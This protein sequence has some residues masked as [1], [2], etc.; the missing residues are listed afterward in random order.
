MPVTTD[1]GSPRTREIPALAS[2]VPP[3]AEQLP[4]KF[5]RRGR[6]R[7]FIRRWI[8]AG[9]LMTAALLAVL[10][11]S[12]SIAINDLLEQ[13]TS[14]ERERDLVRG[15]NERLRGELLRLMSVERVSALASERLGLVQPA[16]PPIALPAQGDVRSHAVGK[17]GGNHETSGTNDA[18]GSK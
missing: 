11:V 3:K 4:L 13:I 16:R 14:L 8:T 18:P 9:M 5:G 15:E 17:S 6:V 7:P 10:Y 2:S 12:N 1:I